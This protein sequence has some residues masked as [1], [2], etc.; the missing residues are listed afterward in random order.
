MKTNENPRTYET[1][2]KITFFLIS[3]LQTSV[4]SSKEKPV[5]KVKYAGISGRMHGEKKEKIPAKKAAGNDMA[6]VNIYPPA[7][8]GNKK[9]SELSG[10]KNFSK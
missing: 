7:I 6:S 10:T 3:A 1:V 5:I 4:N 9:I 8:I 2:E